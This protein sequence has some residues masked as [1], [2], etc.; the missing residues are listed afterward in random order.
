M[1]REPDALP[2]GTGFMDVLAAA[3]AAWLACD[4]K[5]ARELIRRYIDPNGEFCCMRCS[6]MEEELW[7]VNTSEGT[8][9]VCPACA[10]I[11][12][13]DRQFMN[14]MNSSGEVYMEGPKQRVVQT[15]RGPG[16]KTVAVE[17]KQSYITVAK[18]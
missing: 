11:L 8:F 16:V 14:D 18:R 2:D 12:A 1:H 4:H 17:I 6:A 3:Q 15:T 7:R 5:L 9:H 10:T 13:A